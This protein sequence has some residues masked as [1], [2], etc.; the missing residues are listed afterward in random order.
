MTYRSKR[1]S[2]G[3]A[4][5]MRQSANATGGVDAGS[6]SHRRTG[7]GI[8][9]TRARKA[10]H[11]RRVRGTAPFEGQCRRCGTDVPYA[12][13]GRYPQH[14]GDCRRARGRETSAAWKAA[15]R[16]RIPAAVR[17][18]PSKALASLRLWTVR[19]CDCGVTYPWQLR[20]H[21]VCPT[22]G[23]TGLEAVA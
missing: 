20:A 4:A 14:C 22:C 15:N 16:A 6:A 23:R 10:A 8:H 9:A 2:E 3:C 1:A 17:P 21:P 19:R 13:S 18:R 11:M 7:G 5:K 12:G